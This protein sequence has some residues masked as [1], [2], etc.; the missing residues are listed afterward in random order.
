MVELRN[1]ILDEVNKLYLERL[2]VKMEPEELRIED[3]RKRME[4]ELRFKEL[5]ASLDGL[6]GGYF[7]RNKGRG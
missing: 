6:T 2:R 1:D 3:K 4:K 5:T 7:S